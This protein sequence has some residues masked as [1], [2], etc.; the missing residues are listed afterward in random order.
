[1]GL[2]PWKRMALVNITDVLMGYTKAYVL[3]NKLEIDHTISNQPSPCS[4]Y[5]DL[6]RCSLHARNKE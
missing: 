4:C 1:M 6:S 2:S 5:G 3:K